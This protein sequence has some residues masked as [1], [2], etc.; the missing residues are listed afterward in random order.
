MPA[1]ALAV[2]DA[3]CL[4]EREVRIPWGVSAVTWN[5]DAGH[6]CMQRNG[7]IREFGEVTSEVAE[8]ARQLRELEKGALSPR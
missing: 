7:K 1:A 3:C 2:A 6:A 4:T 5:K 8:L